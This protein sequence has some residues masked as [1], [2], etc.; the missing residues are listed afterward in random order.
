MRH[1]GE[2]EVNILSN[3]SF[4]DLAVWER[5]CFDDW[6]EKDRWLNE[7]IKIEGVCSNALAT[8]DLVYAIEPKLEAFYSNIKV[9]VHTLL[10]FKL[11]TILLLEEYVHLA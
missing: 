1:M 2:G 6:E 9:R 11:G 8:L 4:L 5:Q 7:S 3:F 10:S